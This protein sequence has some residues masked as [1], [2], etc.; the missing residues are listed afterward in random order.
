[1]S[2][3]IHRGFHKVYFAVRPLN[4]VWCAGVTLLRLLTTEARERACVIVSEGRDQRARAET[5]DKVSPG[6][7]GSHIRQ[8]RQHAEAGVNQQ[9][10]RHHG[11]YYSV[12]LILMGALIQ[13]VAR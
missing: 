12:L 6:Q 7:G 13:G 9:V 11:Q 3:R 2:H 1:M 10:V 4:V 8:G 5:G